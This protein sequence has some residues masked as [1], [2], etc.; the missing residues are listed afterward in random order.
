MNSV[1]TV[2]VGGCGCFVLC[3]KSHCGSLALERA[4]WSIQRSLCHKVH[5]EV[6]RPDNHEII[7]DSVFSTGAL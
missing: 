1:T 7:I 2:F 5:S 4:P 6:D 3:V